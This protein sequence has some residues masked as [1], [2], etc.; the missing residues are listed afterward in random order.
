KSRVR[1]IVDPKC[2]DGILTQP[3]ALQIFPGV[4]ACRSPE[5]FLEERASPFVNL[6]QHGAELGFFGLCRTRVA[7]LRKR[8]SQL[9]SHRSY[10]FGYGNLL[11]L[12][13][14]VENIAGHAA[15]EALKELPRG[16]LRERRSLL[17][18]IAI[19]PVVILRPS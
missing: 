1:R 18:M 8:N 15:P 12:L 9:L 7:D 16:M 10:S 13:D 2:L 11:D 4:S 14:K 5:V 17:A 19:K 6:E 3:A